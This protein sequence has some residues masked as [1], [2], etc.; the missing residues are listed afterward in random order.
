[1]LINIMVAPVAAD[2]V[3]ALKPRDYLLPVGF[4][5]RDGYHFRAQIYAHVRLFV[6]LMA[7]SVVS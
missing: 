3:V 7:F 5:L 6:N 4:R 2:P 1:M